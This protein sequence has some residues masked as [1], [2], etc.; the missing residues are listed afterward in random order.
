MPIVFTPFIFILI[1]LI[2]TL[3]LLVEFMYPYRLWLFWLPVNGII[4]QNDLLSN[5]SFDS[6]RSLLDSYCIFSENNQT[7]KIIVNITYDNVFWDDGGYDSCF[8]YESIKTFSY[9]HF[10]ITMMCIIISLILMSYIFCVTRLEKKQF[11]CEKRTLINSNPSKSLK[12]LTFGY[13]LFIVGYFIL[14]L[15]TIYLF[16]VLH[17]YYEYKIYPNVRNGIIHLNMKNYNFSNTYDFFKIYNDGFIDSERYKHNVTFEITRFE[18]CADSK[19]TVNEL[20]LYIP[21]TII[22]ICANIIN[23]MSFF[24][25]YYFMCLNAK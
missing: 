10:G 24:A 2:L 23:A 9:V 14:L 11:A 18:S 12:S 8:N 13:I 3:S 5:K 16:V 7:F 19:I 6:A 25:S 17:F 4:Y 15:I 20:F 1:Q 21:I 22:P